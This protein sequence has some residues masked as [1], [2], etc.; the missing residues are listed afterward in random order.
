MRASPHSP[1]RSSPGPPEAVVIASAHERRIGGGGLAPAFAAARARLGLIALLFVLAGL[2]SWS[3]VDRMRGMDGGPGTSLGTL[4]WFLGVWTVMMTAMMLPSVSPTVALYARMTRERSPVAPLVFT[5][6]YLLV[7]A[8]AGI[9][10]FGVSGLGGRLLGDTLAWDRAGRWIAG[11]I[12]I[13]AAAYEVTALKNVCLSKCRSPLGFLLG[14]WRDGLRGALGMGTRHG[15]WCLGCCWALMASLFALGVM[16]IAWM[17]LVAGLI[18]AEKT[19]P[20]GRAVTY[21]TAAILVV[22]GVFLVAA[23][24]AIPGLT[25]PGG[26][27]TQMSR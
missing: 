12:L 15:A 17:A 14:S 19:L 11:G 10:A 25:V 27:M 5:S 4:G 22:L 1:C 16:S 2:A 8:G 9:L 3:T 26:S 23:P 13:A 24:H 21:G 20:R 18:A 7:W 6:G